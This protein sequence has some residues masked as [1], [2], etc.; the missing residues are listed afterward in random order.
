MLILRKNYKL[1]FLALL[2]IAA[3]L[4]FV[5]NLTKEVT[6]ANTMTCSA[7]PYA[8]NPADDITISAVINFT[9]SDVWA[10][11]ENE[12]GIVQ[13]HYSL[14]MDD[15]THYSKAYTTLSGAS[16][17]YDI[18]V[19]ATVDGTGEQVFCNPSTGGAWI[20]KSLSDIKWLGRLRHKVVE[21]NGKL[22]LMG[23]FTYDYESDVWASADAQTWKLIKEEAAWGE[24]RM[25][26][27][28]VTYNN[29]I[30]I[31]GGGKYNSNWTTYTLY[32]DVWSSSDGINWTQ[33]TA[34]ADWS[35]RAYIGYAVW[36]GKMWV[37][38][39]CVEVSGIACI[40]GVNDVWFSTNGSDWTQST[41]D[42]AWSD[43]IDSRLIV[44][45]DGTGDKLWL[46][47]GITYGPSTYQRDVYASADG[48]T[49]TQ[50]TA[51]IDANFEARYGYEAISYDFGSGRKIWVMGGTEA[52]NT[53]H[54]DIWSSGDGIDW[55]MVKDNVALPGIAVQPSKWTHWSPRR[56]FQLIPF[57]DGVS[58]KVWLFGGFDYVKN[59]NDIW[60]TTDGT[61]WTLNNDYYETEYGA[62]FDTAVIPYDNK[63]WLIAG[64][65]KRKGVARDVWSSTDGINWTCEW[66]SYTAGTE[67]IDCNNSTPTWSA[68]W[69]QK[70]MVYDEPADDPDKGEQIFMIGGCTHPGP[71]YGS[72]PT[73]NE[74]REVWSYDSDSDTWTQETATAD[75][76]GRYQ[77]AVAVYNDKMWILGGWNNSAGLKN[78]V[79]YSTN[80]SSWTQ[81]TN[82]SWSARTGHSALVYND[83]LWVM[84]GQTS[85]P[86]NKNDVWY[87]TDP[88]S[89]GWTKATETAAWSARLTFGL[90]NF[91][92]RM[93]VISGQQDGVNF[94]EYLGTKDVYWSIDGVLW[95]S[96]TDTADFS[97]RDFFS[98]TVFQDRI[99]LTGGDSNQGTMDDVWASRYAD[100]TYYVMQSLD[101]DVNIT[102][103][104][105]PE[106][107]IDLSLTSCEFGIL[108]ADKIQTCGYSVA[109]ATNAQ[110]GYTGYIRQ[111]QGFESTMNG[112]T[113]EIHGENG[114]P[115]QIEASGALAG[116]N[117][118][119]G[120]GIL[121]TDTTDWPQFSVACANY[122]NQSSTSL[123]AKAVDWSTAAEPDD[124]LGDNVDNIFAYTYEAVDGV[125]DGLTYFCHGVR[126]KWDTPPGTY[127]QLATIT[128]IANF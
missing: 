65:S 42:A 109:I 44:H 70:L 31:L 107:S 93:W 24:R 68:R 98:A 97:G 28:A 39:G 16:G 116:E 30:W 120:V 119:Y 21:L 92:N 101:W 85:G 53:F 62:R 9:P 5:F 90:L 122:D 121:T 81:T 77:P 56:R 125:N 2:L 103:Q 36:D 6:A 112:I 50:K 111:N 115:L 88:I 74:L 87:T 4:A 45:D 3:G 102:A 40:T 37:A 75:W 118:E 91:N 58:E 55:D 7:D 27:G 29:K 43:R 26:F 127:T 72:C 66:G 34:D 63:L 128:A 12:D 23:G 41:A 8:I 113:H 95:H 110:S 51:L 22:W 78:D 105:E 33:V 48:E 71:T 89:A 73:A 84:G 126:I 25:D 38:G 76:S 80:G 13:S 69:D 1:L 114:T 17:R 86:T 104:V 47:G 123:P 100:L 49:W 35:D 54:N 99:W 108:T 64:V 10:V 19:F 57:N 96:V 60:N 52:D 67:G 124:Y 32:N 59:E 82:A 14:D 83:K 20:K 79:W 11:I 106:I 46:I 18:G 61:T 117:G 94:S 15:S